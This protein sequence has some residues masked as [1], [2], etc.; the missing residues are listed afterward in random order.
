MMAGWPFSRW[1]DRNHE[2]FKMRLQRRLEMYDCVVHA[3]VPLMNPGP[4]G[5][6]A[7]NAD[8]LSE[9]LGA[10]RTKMQMFGLYDEIHAYESLVN[11]LNAK[12]IPEYNRSLRDLSEMTVRNLRKELGYKAKRT[13]RRVS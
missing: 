5:K 9:R 8:E 6:V 1:K 12:N 4:D 11:S 3:T 7:L 10:A 2:I 13:S